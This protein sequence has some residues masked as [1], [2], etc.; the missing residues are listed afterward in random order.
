MT[1]TD[2]PSELRYEIEVDGEVA[3]FLLYR[4]EPGVLE[5]VHTDVDPKWEGRG[6]GGAL[7]KGALD[8]IRARD[9]K[10][11]PFCPFVRAYLRRHPEYQDLVAT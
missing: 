3:G 7:V 10:I 11:R 5:L 9:L 4:V 8:D 1:V 2:R 6:V